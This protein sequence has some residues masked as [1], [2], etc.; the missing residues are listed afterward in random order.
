M[1]WQELCLKN[2]AI[3]AASADLQNQI[4]QLK[5]EAKGLYEPHHPLHLLSLGYSLPTWALRDHFTGECPWTTML[6]NPNASWGIWGTIILS[7][8]QYFLF[9]IHSSPGGEGLH[10]LYDVTTDTEIAKN[11]CF[12]EMVA[13]GFI[14]PCADSTGILNMKPPIC[15]LLPCNT[16]P[17]LSEDVCCWNASK[18][19]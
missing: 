13:W 14:S 17:D 19:K 1:E 6:G 18:K 11:P 15:G 8:M 12:L 2:I 16:S 5:H 4:D 7:E 9:A 3:E 10:C